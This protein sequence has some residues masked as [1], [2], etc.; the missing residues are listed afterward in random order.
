MLKHINLQLFAEGNGAANSGTDANAGKGDGANKAGDDGKQNA[1]K[2]DGSQNAGKSFSQEDVDKIVNDRTERASNAALLSYYQ[3]NGM[4]EVEAK[5]AI[6]DYKSAK[7]TKAEA[8][9]GNNAVLQQKLTDAEKTAQD[10]IAQANTR[11]ISSEARVQAVGLGIKPERVDYA[12]RLADLKAVTVD[13]DGKVDDAAVKA[14]LE[15]VLKDLPELKQT[16]D[17]STGFK[18]GADGAKNTGGADD[19]KMRKAFGLPPKK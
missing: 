3:Q 7:A 2:G 18:V 13:K 17:G 5:Q 12:V 11:I 19:N 10:A 1:G 8:D 9:K 6:A 16:T 15:K 4:T 14:T